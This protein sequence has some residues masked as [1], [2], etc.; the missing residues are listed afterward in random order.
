MKRSESKD[1][2]VN[3]TLRFIGRSGMRW[4]HGA[5]RMYHRRTVVR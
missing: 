4:V 2:T 1:A 5:A 3:T